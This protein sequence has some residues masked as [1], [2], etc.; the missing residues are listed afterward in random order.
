MK[1]KITVQIRVEMKYNKTSIYYIEESIK[2]KEKIIYK[3][4][5]I[6]VKNRKKERSRQKQKRSQIN[7]YSNC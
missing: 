6:Y 2:R 1:K 3:N 7:S 4:K 5:Y